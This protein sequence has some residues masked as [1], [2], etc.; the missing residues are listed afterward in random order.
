[1]K[2]M[3]FFSNVNIV[4]SI[5]V[6][7]ALDIYLSPSKW[8]QRI[9]VTWT[10]F[11]IIYELA[12]T[13]CIMTWC[14]PHHF[15]ILIVIQNLCFQNI[16]VIICINEILAICIMWHINFTLKLASIKAYETPIQ[17]SLQTLATWNLF[18]ISFIAY[19]SKIKYGL[20]EVL[21]CFYSMIKYR[22]KNFG[23]MSQIWFKEIQSDHEIH[24]SFQ[25][26]DF[27]QKL[28]K[29]DS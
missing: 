21:F 19:N 2:W 6:S 7:I 5:F 1:M 8:W 26:V 27:P 13:L 16:I 3:Y 29:L 11:Y 22:N 20:W 14:C 18:M 24:L 9:D 17:L 12:L 4:H 10:R 28:H 23:S 15:G 25:L